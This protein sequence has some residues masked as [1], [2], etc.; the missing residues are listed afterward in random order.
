MPRPQALMLTVLGR[1]VLPREVPVF[2]GTF[3]ALLDRLGVSE[4]AGRST[5]TRM[6][7][8]G[9]LERER[10]GRR[11]CYRL[12]RRS[13]DLLTEGDARIFGEPPSPAEDGTWTLLS[14]SIPES[15]RNDRH[16][17]RVRL[18]WAGFGLLRD[19]LWLAPGR[20]DVADLIDHLGLDGHVEV[21]A[22]EAVAPTDL[23][24][25]VR[26][27][28]DLDG[29]E[30]RYRAFLARWKASPEPAHD[31]LARQV[32]LI[33]E[34]RQL[35]REDPQLPL[36]YLPPNWPGPAARDAFLELV[37]RDR[38]RADAAFAELL[39]APGHPAGATRSTAPYPGA[40]RSV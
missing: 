23:P 15:R 16:S 19:G 38:E 5:L 39:G 10:V 33:T 9:Y 13:R 11:T 25:V 34:W 20:V 28:W 8:R 7:T 6:V 14:F 26:A 1:F 17:L 36:A 37:E 40:P 27:A 35:L 21:F 32:V 29:L 3:L 2:S 18:S 24:R 22:G 31:P 30:R 4:D 12:T